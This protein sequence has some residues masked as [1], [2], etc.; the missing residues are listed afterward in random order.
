MTNEMDPSIIDLP[1]LAQALKAE[2]GLGKPMVRDMHSPGEPKFMLQRKF[3]GEEELLIIFNTPACAFSCDFCNLPSDSL[4]RSGTIFT[5]D[6]IRRQFTQAAVEMRHTWHTL[7]RLTISNDGSVLDE[8]TFPRE[9]LLDIARFTD[10]YKNIRTLVL[11]TRLEFFDP[12]FIGKIKK[13]APDTKVNILT[14]F[15]TLYEE[16]KTKVL[17]KEPIHKFLTG[18]DRV[19]SSGCDLTAYVLFKPGYDMSDEA[20]YLEAEGSIEFLERECTKRNLELTIR[21]NPM[22]K[23]RSTPWAVKAEEHGW[24]PPR[25]TDVLR[26]ARD[27]RRKGIKIYLGLSA[28]DLADSKNTYSGREDYS[29]A[30]IKQA[31]FFNTYP[32]YYLSY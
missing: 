3:L 9:A 28:E 12:D 25:L 32:S 23:A 19:A 20:A 26:L 14:G 5:P 8:K 17:G 10:V 24:Q 27:M 18:L 4:P 30:L 31:I 16:I 6:D 21:L 22:Y 7:D 11:E 1:E 13:I 15:E 2:Y 29:K